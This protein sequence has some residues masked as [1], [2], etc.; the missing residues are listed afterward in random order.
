MGEYLVS[1]PALGSVEAQLAN[2][3]E[4]IKGVMDHAAAGDL[5][6]WAQRITSEAAKQM[7]AESDEEGS[8]F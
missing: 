3:H 1:V 4:V 7:E 2:M 5:Q 6:E 8:Y